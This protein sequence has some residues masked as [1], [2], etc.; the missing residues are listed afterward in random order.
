MKKFCNFVGDFYGENVVN[1]ITRIVSIDIVW[2]QFGVFYGD[3]I[4]KLVWRL[5]VVSWRKHGKSDYQ[6]IS[7]S[8]LSENLHKK[9]H[10]AYCLHT[11]YITSTYYGDET[12][13]NKQGWL[14]VT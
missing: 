5:S 13:S 9:Y 10:C 3:F 7:I 2:G 8:I 4:V 11:V 12:F 1:L 14:L 6:T